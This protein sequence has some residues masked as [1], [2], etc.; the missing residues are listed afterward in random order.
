MPK[1]DPHDSCLKCLGEAHLADAC[2]ICRVFKPRTKREW[3]SCLKLLLMEAALQ[4]ALAGQ[5]TMCSAP[6]STRGTPV[7]SKTSAPK[8]P[9]HR[10]HS[11]VPK[12]P[13]TSRG[14]SP[15]RKFRA[16][17][18]RWH[19]SPTRGSPS[20]TVQKRAD[21]PPVSLGQLTWHRPSTLETF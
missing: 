15:S 19:T 8:A 20:T 2:K 10:S 3:D 9:R 5:F 7:H 4:L 1:G 14:R 18:H 17:L 12:R 21:I 16:S 13:Q 11:P 6:A